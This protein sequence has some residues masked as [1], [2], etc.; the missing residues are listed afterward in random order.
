ML[1]L[2]FINT[3]PFFAWLLRSSWQAAVLAVLVL[4]AQWA[5]KSHLS[6]R[7]RHNLWLIVLL[8]L[9]LPAL[10]PSPLSIFNLLHYLPSSHPQPNQ[11]SQAT[12]PPV[13]PGIA[14]I[15]QPLSSA[16]PSPDALAASRTHPLNSP[17]PSSPSPSPGTPGEGRGEGS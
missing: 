13:D 17:I 6:P 3:N 2:A 9:L 16:V 1:P 12:P 5:L 7:W 4:L 10:P 14:S 8:R 15:Q 11:L